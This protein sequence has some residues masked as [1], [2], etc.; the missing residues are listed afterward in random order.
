MGSTAVRNALVLANWG[1]MVFVAIR[2]QEQVRRSEVEDA[3][4]RQGVGGEALA[5]SDEDET[6]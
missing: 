1:S 5:K 3:I 4:T 6:V 2:A